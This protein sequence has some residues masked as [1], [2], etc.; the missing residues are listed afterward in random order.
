MTLQGQIQ[1]GP[2]CALSIFFL[3]LRRSVNLSSFREEGEKEGMVPRDL[4]QV[5]RSILAPH[6]CSYAR[7]TLYVHTHRYVNR[8]LSF[9]FLFS[10]CD[11]LGAKIVQLLSTHY[12]N[13]L[14]IKNTFLGLIF[15][16]QRRQRLLR[17]MRLGRIR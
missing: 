16:L 2:P 7:L 8:I 3:L 14:L 1:P 10:S 13:T 17:L 9:F 12:T 4:R 5:C 6:T 15:T 11:S